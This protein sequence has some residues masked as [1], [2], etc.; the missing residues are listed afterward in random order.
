MNKSIAWLVVFW[1]CGLYSTDHG[2]IF[3]FSN[4]HIILQFLEDFQLKSKQLL[5]SDTSSLFEAPVVEVDIVM[6]F[7]C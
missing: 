3:F 1:I 6:K 7:D 4:K 5:Y 2:L